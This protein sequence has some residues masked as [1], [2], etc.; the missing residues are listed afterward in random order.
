MMNSATRIRSR[1]T[2]AQDRLLQAVPVRLLRTGLQVTTVLV[3][4]GAALNVFDPFENN[5][6]ETRQVA[7]QTPRQARA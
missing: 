3:F 2:G 1:S 4:I 7:Q 6:A 5:T